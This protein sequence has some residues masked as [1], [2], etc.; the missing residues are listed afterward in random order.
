MSQETQ[1][2]RVFKIFN[3]E[4]FFH[5]IPVNLCESIKKRVESVEMTIKRVKG[6]FQFDVH[7]AIYIKKPKASSGILH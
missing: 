7:F 3:M 4:D 6:H 1:C 5:G 2:C